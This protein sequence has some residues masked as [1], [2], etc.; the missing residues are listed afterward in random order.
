[1]TLGHLTFSSE[2]SLWIGVIDAALMLAVTFGLPLTGDQKGAIDAFL[3]V[4]ASVVIRSQ[5][6]PVKTV[7]AITGPADVAAILDPPPVAT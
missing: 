7:A 4:L 1:M 6:V 2:P 3:A 5:V